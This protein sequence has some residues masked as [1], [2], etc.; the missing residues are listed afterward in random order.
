V[1]LS[2]DA[3]G[4]WSYGPLGGDLPNP[5][6]EGKRLNLIALDRSR[7]RPM[8]LTCTN[9]HGGVYAPND[10]CAPAIEITNASGTYE[11]RGDADCGQVPGNCN[12]AD[13]TC[14]E[15]HMIAD[16]KFLPIN[17]WT[18]HFA[19]DAGFDLPSLGPSQTRAGQLQRLRKINLMALKS[20]LEYPDDADELTGGPGS[21]QLTGIQRQWLLKLYGGDVNPANNVAPLE[22][23]TPDSW[24]V[25]G[26]DSATNR[27]LWNKVV[28]PGCANCH[29]AL[30]PQRPGT[31]GCGGENTEPFTIASWA[32]FSA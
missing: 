1:T 30:K 8:P 7:A 10:S 3:S 21:D 32:Q 15:K 23:T 17:P 14:R 20:P 24:L 18:V 26:T 27:D 2:Q 31:C 29:M 16:T 22:D 9:C 25:S 13:G 11:I 5:S 28:L 19:D 4:A 12:T 6:G